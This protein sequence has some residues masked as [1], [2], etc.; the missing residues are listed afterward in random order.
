M[1]PNQRQ[2]LLDYLLDSKNEELLENLKKGVAQSDESTNIESKEIQRKRNRQ[3]EST[4]QH[5]S[6]TDQRKSAS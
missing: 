6:K 2:K 4:P 3:T 5:D 1:P